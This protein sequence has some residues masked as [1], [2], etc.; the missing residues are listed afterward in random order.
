MIR[1][2]QEVQENRRALKY[3]GFCLIAWAAISLISRGI[4]S[5]RTDEGWEKIVQLAKKDEPNILDSGIDLN[6]Y[7]AAGII[8]LTIAAIVFGLFYIMYL[9]K[10]KTTNELERS[11]SVRVWA[12]FAIFSLFTGIY[13][14][15]ANLSL[16]SFL[17]GLVIAAPPA[18]FAWIYPSTLKGFEQ[19]MEEAEEAETK[20]EVKPNQTKSEREKQE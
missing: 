2:Y 8:T 17:D 16:Q 13:A 9:R 11:Y 4:A 19:N 18:G 20:A 15:R 7:L 5:L 14:Q 10:M 3:G 1:E 12:V 6:F